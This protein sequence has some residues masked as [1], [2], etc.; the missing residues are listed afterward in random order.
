MAYETRIF[1]LSLP[2]SLNYADVC[3]DGACWQGAMRNQPL[4]TIIQSQA[5]M[6]EKTSIDFALNVMRQKLVGLLAPCVC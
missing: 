2:R 6:I 4:P 1:S 5:N 3:L